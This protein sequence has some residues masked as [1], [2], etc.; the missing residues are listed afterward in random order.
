MPGA[1][2]EQDQ[3]Q[4][5]AMNISGIKPGAV[6]VGLV[7]SI[8]G[9]AIVNA[10]GN[11]VVAAPVVARTVTGLIR[12]PQSAQTSAPVAAGSQ[13]LLMLFV[14]GCLFS[15]AGGIVAARLAKQA[16][17]KNGTAVGVLAMILGFFFLFMRNPLTVGGNLS[18][19]S[20]SLL[21]ILSSVPMSALG[22]YFGSFMRRPNA[23]GNAS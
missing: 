8:V 15:I 21:S 1:F 4:G 3:A 16:E 14:F 7:L 5:E 13:M 17:V 22:G 23:S 20:F 2:G 19:F 18:S 6:V 10:I 11:A 12:D 9:S